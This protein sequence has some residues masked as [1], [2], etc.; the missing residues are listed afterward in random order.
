MTFHHFASLTV[1]RVRH[2]LHE[3]PVAPLKG[4]CVLETEIV[5]VLTHTS[6]LIAILRHF[7]QI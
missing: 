6:L 2:L 1:L 4:A 7:S 3:P 5:S